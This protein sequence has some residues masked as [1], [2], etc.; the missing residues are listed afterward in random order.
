M[1][2]TKDTNWKKGLKDASMVICDLITAKE[3]SGDKRIRPFQLISD[4]SLKELI[5]L[6]F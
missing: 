2:S 5:Q 4:D 1:C 6:A 3:F